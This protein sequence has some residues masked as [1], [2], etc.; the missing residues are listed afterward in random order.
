MS[1]TVKDAFEQ[2]SKFL[3]GNFL[4]EFKKA[5]SDQLPIGSEVETTHEDDFTVEEGALSIVID[6]FAPNSSNSGTYLKRSVDFVAIG[7]RW[8]KVDLTTILFQASFMHE[9]DSL[10]IQ[11]RKY[12][13]FL[14]KD[15]SKPETLTAIAKW[16]RDGDLHIDSFFEKP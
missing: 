5:I 10:Q 6:Y 9:E 7:E 11:D 15:L 13:K 1:R 8:K 12:K 14:L 2:A 3:E 16:I 4:K